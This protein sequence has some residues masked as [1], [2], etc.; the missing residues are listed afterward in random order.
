MKY[1]FL[2]IKGVYKKYEPFLWIRFSC[3]QDAEPQQED[4]LLFLP[5]KS[6][7]VPGTHLI[8]FRIING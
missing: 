3:L 1:L 6:P 4:S 7:E 8:D 2:S 5:T